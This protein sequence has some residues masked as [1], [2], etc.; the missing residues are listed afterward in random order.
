V[1]VE[2]IIDNLYGLAPADFTRARN[3]AAAE[4]RNAGRRVEAD[5]IKE[6]R[7]PTAAAAAVNRLVRE[8]RADVEEYLRLAVATRDAQLAGKGDPAAAARV[9]RASLERLTRS[10]GEAARQSLL[11]AAVDEDAARELLA[12]RLD[13]ELEPRGLGTLLA[14]VQPGAAREPKAPAAAPRPD[15]RAA[16]TKLREATS[17]LTKARA[18]ELDAQERLAKARTEVARAAAAVERAQGELDRLRSR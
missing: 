1:D 8:H 11:A 10:G 2:E 6:L 7:K 14:H 4:L 9:A 18:A 3:E 12:G 13:R 15:D 16:R 5:R 17:A